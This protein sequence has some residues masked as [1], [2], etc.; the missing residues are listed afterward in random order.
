MAKLTNVFV[1][2]CNKTMIRLLY[3]L[4]KATQSSR[5]DF[6]AVSLQQLVPQIPHLVTDCVKS[7]DHIFR[8]LLIVAFQGHCKFTLCRLNLSETEKTLFQKF[9]AAKLRKLCLQHLFDY[10]QITISEINLDT[11]SA[12]SHHLHK[13]LIISFT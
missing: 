1:K 3:E 12:W 7:W 11:L 2:I 6:C 13:N 10:S 9:K 8:N 4:L 5:L